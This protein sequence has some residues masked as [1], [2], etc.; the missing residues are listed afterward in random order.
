MPRL[1]RVSC[2]IAAPPSPTLPPDPVPH[3]TRNL[4][5][6]RPPRD[7]CASRT[8]SA[9]TAGRPGGY[10]PGA[11]AT[12]CGGPANPA[13]SASPPRGRSPLQRPRARSFSSDLRPVGGHI[14]P[15]RSIHVFT[16]PP[17]G[18]RLTHTPPPGRREAR[19]RSTP[20][21]RPTHGSIVSS[22]HHHAQEAGDTTAPGKTGG[23]TLGIT[24]EAET[25]SAATMKDRG[26]AH[27]PIKPMLQRGGPR[28][29][30]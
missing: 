27:Q 23:G 5:G 8:G 2:L 20:H 6:A 15:R 11:P 7:P 30:G 10:R 18:A 19:G 13:R 24:E 14:S 3:R 28:G 17:T 1:A 4:G 29:A 22:H 16:R 12:E 9:R 25:A 21:R 26:G